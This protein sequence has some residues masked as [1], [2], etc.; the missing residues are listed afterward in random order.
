MNEERVTVTPL[1][2]RRLMRV[3]DFLL[4][5][6]Q[7]LFEDD[8]V[9]IRRIVDRLCLVPGLSAAAPNIGFYLGTVAPGGAYE[10]RLG[11]LRDKA[12]IIQ[13]ETEGVSTNHD[14]PLI[15]VPFEA[16]LSGTD[17]ASWDLRFVA[18]LAN[19]IGR[20][21]GLSPESATELDVTAD[22]LVGPN[23]YITSSD[24][25][26]SE[27]H[28]LVP[29][30]AALA[31]TASIEDYVNQSSVPSSVPAAFGIV[32]TPEDERLIL[33]GRDCVM[34]LG[35]EP[36]VNYR[37]VF[38][39]ACTSWLE[40]LYAGKFGE[41]MNARHGGRGP[42]SLRKISGRESIE[43]SHSFADLAVLGFGF[44]L[45]FEEVVADYAFSHGSPRLVSVENETQLVVRD[46]YRTI[47][48]KKGLFYDFELV[49]RFLDTS[50]LLPEQ[51]FSLD[52][53]DQAEKIFAAGAVSKTEIP[54][55]GSLFVHPEYY[56]FVHSVDKASGR[57]L[58]KRALHEES[59]GSNSPLDNAADDLNSANEDAV[60]F[61][62]ISGPGGSGPPLQKQGVGVYLAWLGADEFTSESEPLVPEVAFGNEGGGITGNW[63]H[64]DSP[65]NHYLLLNQVGAY[66][67]GWSVEYLTGESTGPR[68]AQRISG[69]A[70][71]DTGEICV[72]LYS[73][74]E[75]S[76]AT[77]SMT[78]S[79]SGLHVT[80]GSEVAVR[81]SNRSKTPTLSPGALPV[82]VAATELPQRLIWF[83]LS[84]RQQAKIMVAARQLHD[85]IESF[86]RLG[87]G[88]AGD[89]LRDHAEWNQSREDMTRI[90]EEIERIVVAKFAYGWHESDL[91][92]G[93]LLLRTS[94]AAEVGGPSSG[95]PRS[96]LDWLRVIAGWSAYVPMSMPTTEEALKL[97]LSVPPAADGLP[98][99]VVV[100]SEGTYKYKFR[101]EA[102]TF[103]VEY[104]PGI[105]LLFGVLHVDQTEPQPWDSPARIPV[106]FGG[107]GL[108]YGAFTGL[109]LSSGYGYSEGPWLPEDFQGYGELADLSAGGAI[110][111]GASV[112][113]TLLTLS[114]AGLH[115]PMVVNFSGVTELLGGGAS[116]GVSV[117]FGYLAW[118]I[119]DSVSPS[120]A[121]P[122]FE[123][124]A[125]TTGVTWF[126][127]E[128][129]VLRPEAL[130]DLGAFAAYELALL[131]MASTFVK[132]SGDADTLGSTDFNSNLA[133]RRAESVASALRKIMGRALKASITTESRGE[134]LAGAIGPDETAN[135]QFRRAVISINGRV[136]LF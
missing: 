58:V 95:Q 62:S 65:Y 98:S 17:D 100:G 69:K 87:L 49:S 37:P 2:V 130:D 86:F 74:S 1:R 83:P 105:D 120:T 103:T 54:V 135:E 24:T 111:E 63:E 30:E 20:T 25:A 23:L 26:A 92:S 121:P 7:P 59:V 66:V 123:F 79:K 8:D 116:A 134:V 131:N 50:R 64:F 132:I 124:M 71:G 106:A 46:S 85:A 88:D 99:T 72:R 136:F 108:G 107:V 27:L 93:F 60:D 122:G 104:G 81:Y 56:G 94:L 110:G 42:L 115:P 78:G 102:G 4:F 14:D 91:E 6:P 114:G 11:D 31:P 118:P 84:I 117:L 10:P 109:L 45:S 101:L 82:G 36:P 80:P 15:T 32:A 28:T 126:D 40:G 55:R 35:S 18:Q 34:R 21:A 125:N 53:P 61:N 77:I 12:V 57:V 129:D 70:D 52:G 39:P 89:S 13:F 113:A 43:R 90:S 41:H 128:S 16:L 33:S 47:L 38:C 48:K 97:S 29:W 5:L 112:G 22:G 51:L 96:D 3:K 75:E 44:G 68:R 119:A 76:E 73:S 133:L 127:L 9:R 67:E 19:I